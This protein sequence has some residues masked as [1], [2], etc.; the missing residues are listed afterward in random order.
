MPGNNA[1]MQTMACSASSYIYRPSKDPEPRTLGKDISSLAKYIHERARTFL[2]PRK[3][4]IFL[5]VLML[6]LT[7]CARKRQIV[8]YHYVV[9]EYRM[10]GE[11]DKTKYTVEGIE[12]YHKGKLELLEM[13]IDRIIEDAAE[14]ADRR[15][16]L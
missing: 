16:G 12:M 7:G 1:V 15:L 10:A 11:F 8:V 9:I 14:R 3:L 4:L 2:P 6:C 13:R 5:L